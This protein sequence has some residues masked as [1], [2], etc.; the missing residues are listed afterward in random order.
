[1]AAEVWTAIIGGAAGMASG[2]VASLIAPWV[3]WGIEK[4]RLK[5]Q[6]R[7]DLLDSWRAGIASMVSTDHDDFIRT[8]W[9]ETLRPY[10]REGR[11]TQLEKPGT[12]IV[13]SESGR[14]VKDLF[15][16]EVDRIESGWGL[17]P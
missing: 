1:M 8:D 13:P 2:A 15:T 12:V 10:L 4:R 14:G 6:R 17:R 11:R 9:Y 7:Y 3:K 5:R 16:H